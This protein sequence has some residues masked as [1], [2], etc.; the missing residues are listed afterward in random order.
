MHMSIS[1]KTDPTHH[2]KP[3]YIYVHTTTIWT[4]IADVIPA[5]R[6]TEPF[7]NV[8]ERNLTGSPSHY[9][10]ININQH[11][12]HFMHTRNPT[13]SRKTETDQKRISIVGPQ[14]KPKTENDE[15]ATT[16]NV[17]V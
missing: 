5:L 14:R 3:G 4:R 7:R 11:I 17:Q 6:K 10:R 8:A 1:K 2:L 16:V 12:Y 9:L 13:L 15:R